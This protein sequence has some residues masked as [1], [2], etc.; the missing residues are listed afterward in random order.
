[1]SSTAPITPLAQS[2][3]IEQRIRKHREEVARLRAQVGD[4]QEAL[5]RFMTERFVVQALV[6]EDR[7]AEEPHTSLWEDDDELNAW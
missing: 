1:M 7:G 5:F 3:R 6:P 2:G 4:P